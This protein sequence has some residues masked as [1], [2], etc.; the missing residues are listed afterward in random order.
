MT[1]IGGGVD[2]PFALPCVAFALLP[3]LRIVPSTVKKKSRQRAGRQASCTVIHSTSVPC[4]KLGSSF[5][6]LEQRDCLEQ[7]TFL[8]LPCYANIGANASVPYLIK[9]WN[10]WAAHETFPCF[11]C[12]S[13]RWSGISRAQSLRSPIYLTVRPNPTSVRLVPTRHGGT[14]GTQSC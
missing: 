7:T 4:V 3:H 14:R 1:A 9:F 11:L 2:G 12:P 6:F 5:P 10:L 8:Y 13:T